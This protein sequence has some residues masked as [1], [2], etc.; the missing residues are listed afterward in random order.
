MLRTRTKEL[1]LQKSR[2]E[3]EMKAAVA[4][5]RR[6]Q[7]DGV[8]SPKV[9]R[10]GEELTASA[11]KEYVRTKPAGQRSEDLLSLQ[12]SN[13]HVSTPVAIDVD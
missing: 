9:R 6:M 2:H 11:L 1:G 10:R 8:P 3:P 5:Y 12:P 7:Q 13:T 4:A